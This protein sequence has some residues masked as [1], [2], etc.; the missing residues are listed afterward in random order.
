[1]RLM[2]RDITV[3]GLQVTDS[4][5]REHFLKC[6]RQITHIQV[7]WEWMGDAGLRL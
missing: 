7:T 2:I 4:P 6:A 3:G 5:S 1:M